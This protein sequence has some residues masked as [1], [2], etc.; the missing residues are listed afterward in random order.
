MDKLRVVEVSKSS[1]LDQIFVLYLSRYVSYR[2]T[3]FIF[4]VYAG[5]VQFHRSN[6]V[7]PKSTGIEKHWLCYESKENSV[8]KVCTWSLLLRGRDSDHERH[9]R[10]K[11]QHVDENGSHWRARVLQL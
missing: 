1:L 9:F 7:G 8:A 2:T 3:A 4:H 5:R 11:S 10:S 6:C